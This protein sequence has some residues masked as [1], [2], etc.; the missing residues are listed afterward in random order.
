MMMAA[1]MFDRLA[2]SAMAWAWFPDE[3]VNTPA[4]RCSSVKRA[5]ALQAPR[6]LKA[7][8]RWKFSHLKN[9]CALVRAL[10][11]R[12]VSTGVRCAMPAMR[13]AAAWMS[14]N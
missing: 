3:K 11:V 13:A 7:P 9:S 4:R 5:S 10:A 2:A 1:L 8:A 14:V 12:E 6:N